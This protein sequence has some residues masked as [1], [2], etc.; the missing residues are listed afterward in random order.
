MNDMSLNL[1]EK[2]ITMEKENGNEDDDERKF[3]PSKAENAN[4][5]I[6][7][8]LSWSLCRQQGVPPYLAAFMW[9][10]LLNLL[11]PQERLVKMGIAHSMPCKPCNQEHGS[12]KHEP[13]DCSYNDNL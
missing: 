1:T 7:W 3:I 4:R 11:C 10:M 13:L 6:D 9:K 5:E 2:H 8:E 12:L